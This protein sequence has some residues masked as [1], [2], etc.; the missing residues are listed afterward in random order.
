MGKDVTMLKDLKQ[1]MY[2]SSLRLSLA[3]EAVNSYVVQRKPLNSITRTSRGRAVKFRRHC[4]FIRDT[5]SFCF[6]FSRIY[7]RKAVL[8]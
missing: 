3:S 2:L 8:V 7:V 4:Q 1:Y 5:C 6:A